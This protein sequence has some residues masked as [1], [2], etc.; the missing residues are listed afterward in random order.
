MTVYQCAD[1]PSRPVPYQCKN[2]CLEALETVQFF[3]W[4]EFFNVL[5]IL[6]CLYFES[7]FFQ[8]F[9]PEHHHQKAE[10]ASKNSTVPVL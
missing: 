9:E 4:L 1:V 5:Q 7:Q 10:A 2:V 6:N 3:S 8:E